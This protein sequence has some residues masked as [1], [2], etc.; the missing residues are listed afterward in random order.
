MQG[1]MV[2]EFVSTDMLNSAIAKLEKSGEQELGTGD[3]RLREAVATALPRLVGAEAAKMSGAD[4]DCLIVGNAPDELIFSLVTCYGN[5]ERGIMLDGGAQT[6][7]LVHATILNR[8]IESYPRRDDLSID[9]DGFIAR[10]EEVDPMAIFISNPGDPMADA[11]DL[12]FVERLLQRTDAVVVVDETLAVAAPRTAA[13]L[14]GS[15]ANLCVVR[16]LT[17]AHPVAGFQIAYG[18]ASPEIARKVRSDLTYHPVDTIT[19]AIGVEICENLGKF[20]GFERSLFMRRGYLVERLRKLSSCK[21]FES[22]SD[23]VLVE[24]SDAD[25]ARAILKR[26][27]GIALDPLEGLE[28]SRRCLKVPVRGDDDNISLIDALA[29]CLIQGC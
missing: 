1:S 11:L 29:Q 27:F 18:I 28:L 6:C 22:A 21:V 20:E 14:V 10:A 4:A 19:Q 9:E 26:D 23:F 8:S 5:L 24:I 13:R 2:P 15:H 25:R 7:A 17:Y 12:G 3:S 16:S